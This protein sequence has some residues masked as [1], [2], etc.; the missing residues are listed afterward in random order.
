MRAIKQTWMLNAMLDHHSAVDSSS[1][2]ETDDLFAITKPKIDNY[3]WRTGFECV[4]H[5]GDV[6]NWNWMPH[7]PTQ[8]HCIHAN[9]IIHTRLRFKHKAICIVI[10]VIGLS[11]MTAVWWTSPDWR[12]IWNA[13]RGTAM[14]WTLPWIEH[15]WGATVSVRI[16]VLIKSFMS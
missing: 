4:F 1:V 5:A 9:N 15:C 3:S 6:D 2:E 12:L 14:W 11:Q 16:S 7:I 8:W 10:N 13:F